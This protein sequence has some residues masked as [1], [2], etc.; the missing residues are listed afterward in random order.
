MDQLII[1]GGAALGVINLYQKNLMNKNHM[2][3]ENVSGRFG[4]NRVS[5]YVPT[6]VDRPLSYQGRVSITY[7]ETFEYLKN[8]G[9]LDQYKEMD[10]YYRTV[11]P[12]HFAFDTAQVKEGVQYPQT[13]QLY[14]D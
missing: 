11:H 13:M 1:F 9:I 4:G 10:E 6:Q 5:G 2:L 3:I 12:Q 7:P 8:N 14:R